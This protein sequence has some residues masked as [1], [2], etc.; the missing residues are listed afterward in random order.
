MLPMPMARP[1]VVSP[2]S[3][4]DLTAMD[5]IGWN[6]ASAGPVVTASLAVD[7]GAS[8]TDK[9]H[10]K[11]HHHRDGQCQCGGND[12]RRY[13]D[14]RHNNGQCEWGMDIHAGWGLANGAHTITA[15]ETDLSGTTGTASLT[16]TLDTAA[17]VAP[18]ITSFSTDSGTVGDGITNDNTLTLTGTAEANSTVKVYDGVDAVGQRH[19]QQ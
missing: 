18:S 11:C 15:S 16:F 6:L 1:G 5:V 10:I 13:D 12:H 9:N 7:T 19:C 3:A 2:F 8:S 17:P 4:S 14:A